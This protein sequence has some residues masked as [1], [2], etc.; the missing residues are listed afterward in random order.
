MKQYY[1]KPE[2]DLCEFGSKENLLD[3]SVTFNLN[4]RIMGDGDD[5][6]KHRGNDDF[7]EEW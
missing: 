3:G 4:D 1:I 6:S 5:L 2:I 7:D